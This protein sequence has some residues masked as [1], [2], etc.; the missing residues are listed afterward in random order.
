[1]K[2]Q[3]QMMIAAVAFAIVAV[4]TVDAK[5]PRPRGAKQSA[6]Q[7]RSSR[8][9]KMLRRSTDKT[10]A[11]STKNLADAKK[12]DAPEV[13]QQD[14]AAA[15]MENLTD[16]NLSEA[17]KQLIAQRIKQADL[18]RD[19]KLK[20][21]EM[22]DIGYGWFGLGTSKEQ[23]EQHKK[24]KEELNTM[25]SELAV[26][27]KEIRRL[28]V[29]TGKRYSNTVRYALG[30]LTAVGITATAYAIDRYAFEGK[31]FA[32]VQDAVS[33]YGNNLTTAAKSA[34]SYARERGIRGMGSDAYSKL[35]SFR[36]SAT[37]AAKEATT[38]AAEAMPE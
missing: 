9:M 4:T 5:V 29:E 37:A 6:Q 36:S 12:T 27:N 17:Q 19:I 11:Q 3:L 7:Q 33:E 23:Q 24:A 21:F 2:K 13:E 18:E 20:Q 26:I 34:Y 31:N 15:V 25:K 8:K 35:P 22:S 32:M 16:P 28:E 10:L 1:M 38:A 30:V 14:T